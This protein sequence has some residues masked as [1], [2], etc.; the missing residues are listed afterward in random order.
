MCATHSNSGG[1]IK[2][3]VGRGFRKIKL[4]TL[5]CFGSSVGRDMLML[6][7]TVRNYVGFCKFVVHPQH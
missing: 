2:Q 6:M 3:P 1:G 5:V 7:L 4:S